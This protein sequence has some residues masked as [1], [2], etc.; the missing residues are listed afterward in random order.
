MEKIILKSI[1]FVIV[2][3]NP[4]L[5][6]GQ[7]MLPVWKHPMSFDQLSDQKVKIPIYYIGHVNMDSLAKTVDCSKNAQ[8]NPPIGKGYVTNITLENSGIWQSYDEN[9]KISGEVGF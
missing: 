6:F 4:L 2:V 7:S 3:F 8:C 1:I 5:F 9:H